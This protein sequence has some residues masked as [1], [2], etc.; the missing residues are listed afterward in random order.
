MSRRTWIRMAMM[1]G[2]LALLAATAA[3]GGDDD[4][5]GDQGQAQQLQANLSEWKIGLSE[6]TVS[7]GK[8]EIAAENAGTM[9]H[10]LVIIRTDTA[11]DK[12]PV[13]ASQKVDE[14][15][16]GDVIDEIE[17]FKA[18]TTE[19]KTIDLAAGAYVLICNIPEH[20]EAGMRVGLTVK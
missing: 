6:S 18:G 13:S 10:E 11:P 16:A 7:A 12:L 14:A 2:L 17:E 15:K 19:T 5:G 8:V 20:Y 1:G 4:G 3:C 9:V